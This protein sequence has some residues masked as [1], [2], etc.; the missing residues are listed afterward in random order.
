[1]WLTDLIR[2]I[3]FIDRILELQYWELEEDNS[4]PNSPERIW[5]SRRFETLPMWT[6]K[7]KRQLCWMNLEGTDA[8]N[9]VKQ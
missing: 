2:A 1:M 6:H 8:N 4:S 5:R 3:S 9:F 7:E